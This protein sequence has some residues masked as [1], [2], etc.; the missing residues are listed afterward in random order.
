RERQFLDDGV[1][2]L[3]GGQLKGRPILQC[4]AAAT[5]AGRTNDRADAARLLSSSA[6]LLDGQPAAV[7]DAVAELLHR[8]YPR[9][10]WLAGVQP[11][12]L[13]EHLVERALLE[14]P[15]LLGAV[16]GGAR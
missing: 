14:D 11:D 5:L 7:V 6:P 9:E 3:A 13:G 2:S 1:E 12:L 4:A 15:D 8:L 16:F 10:A